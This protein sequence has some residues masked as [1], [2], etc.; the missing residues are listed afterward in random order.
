VLALDRSYM[1]LAPREREGR[2]VLDDIMSER[3]QLLHFVRNYPW[4][5]LV[6]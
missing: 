4:L 2:F 5:M 1:P 6:S 3:H